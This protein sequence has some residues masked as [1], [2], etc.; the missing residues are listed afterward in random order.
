MTASG[1]AV[2]CRHAR[3]EAARGESLVVTVQWEIAARLLA[4]PG[5]KIYGAL[6]AL[7]QSLADV[8]LI[9]RLPPAVFWPRPKVASA[10]VLLPPGLSQ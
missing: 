6:G 10:M 1:A 7:V 4:R 2:Q 9:R 5:R 3:V 8:R